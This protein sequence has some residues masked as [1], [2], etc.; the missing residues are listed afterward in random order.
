MARGQGNDLIAAALEEWIIGN[1]QHVNPL[2][3]KARKCRVDVA[4]CAGSYGINL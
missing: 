3:D 2:L 4:L 1:Q